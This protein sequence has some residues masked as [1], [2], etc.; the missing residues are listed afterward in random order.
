MPEGRPSYTPT[1]SELRALV[2]VAELGSTA[3]AADA[4]SLTQSAVSRSVGALEERLAVRLFRRERQRMIL[5][6][7]GRAMLRDARD[8]LDRLDASA[9][10]IMAFGGGSEV[11]RLAVLPTFAT[12][13]LIP[14]LPA[15]TRL[16]PDVSLDLGQALLPVDFEASPFDA[17]IQRV[18]MAPRHQCPAP[19]P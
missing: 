15:F 7:A 9:R 10:M 8:I 12:A 13:W 2:R 4:L 11:L 18:E 16:H 3:A 6:D 17:A 14:R 5:S 19:V 1:I